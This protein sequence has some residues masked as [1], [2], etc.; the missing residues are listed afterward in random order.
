[1]Q[2]ERLSKSDLLVL[3]EYTM[4]KDA[5]FAYRVKKMLTDDSSTEGIDRTFDRVI[6][7]YTS[8][9]N[10]LSKLE[11]DLSF[12]FGYIL[13]N[14]LLEGHTMKAI[15]TSIQLYRRISESFSAEAF[16]SF[17]QE[18]LLVIREG[19][20]ELLGANPLMLEHPMIVEEFKEE[21]RLFKDHATRE[22]I[23][24]IWL[25]IP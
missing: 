14:L 11:E 17:S 21:L 6:S 23:E 22:T 15:L 3:V 16:P 24:K 12:I 19:K 7:R 18:L 2:L 8:D 10:Q 1:M 25:K 20:S 9:Q 4:H 5:D 13:E